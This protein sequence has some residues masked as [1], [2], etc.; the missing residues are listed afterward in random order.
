MCCTALL[1]G[2]GST[3]YL[4]YT[5][6]VQHYQV[7]GLQHIYAIHVLYS[8]TRLRVYNIFT[9]YMCCTALPGSGSTTYLRYTCAVQH[10]Q[11]PGLQHIYAIHVLYSITRLRVYNI[12]TLY[13]CCTALPGPG[14]TTIL[15]SYTCAV[16]HYQVPGLQHIYAIH[17]LYSITRSRVY[18][19]FTLY[20]C[21]T[22]LPGPGSTTYLRY[23]CAVQHYQVPG[24]QHIYAI[25]VLYSITRSRV[26]NIFTL[27]M[28]CTALPGPGSTCAYLRYTCAVQHYQVPG[29]QHIYAIHVLYSMTRLRVYNIFTLYM[30]CTALPG[31]GSTTYL[32]Y[33]CAVQ[34]Y[35]V[36][37]LQHIYAIHVLYSMTR[38]RVYNIFT[39]YMCCTALPGPGSTTYLRYTCA[40]QH[41]Q[42]PGLQHIY[43]IHVLYSITRSRVYNIFTLY[44]C[45]TALPGP[46]STTYLRYTCAVQH[47]QAPGSTTYLRYTCAVQHDQAP[48]STT[49]LRYT[50]AVQ[51]YQVPGLQHIY[52]IHVLY[53]ITRSRV[54]NIFT[55]YMCCTA[56]PGPGSTTYL[57]YTCAVQHYQV[58]GL[59]HIYAIH[60]LYSITRLRVY[61]KLTPYMCCTALPGVNDR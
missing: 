31:P 15:Y 36:P 52:A 30:C 59:Q 61:N 24:L 16:Q 13:M 32:R 58:P 37:G 29:L 55:L 12:F 17:V 4:R 48:G 43:A 33:T 49:Y 7:P 47:Y 51:H 28:C 8:M 18:N 23:T 22:A 10:Y 19:I 5:C 39:L 44:M 46:G 3:T 25:H 11:V 14:S 53:S 1:P 6:A 60:V 34:H 27:Y 2:P 26:Y 50:C 42:V 9:P 38:L 45:C 41:Y 54:Y 57:R 56:L 20:M 40:V 35:Q 21:C